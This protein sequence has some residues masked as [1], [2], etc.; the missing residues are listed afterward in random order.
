MTQ[1]T[2]SSQATGTHRQLKW[3]R[4]AMAYRVVGRLEREEGGEQSAWQVLEFLCRRG[5]QLDH[6]NTW[7]C[8]IAHLMLTFSPVREAQLLSQ[9]AKTGSRATRTDRQ[10]DTLCN[11]ELV[12]WAACCHIQYDFLY[13][14]PTP[15]FISS[16][17][18]VSVS[19]SVP[20]STSFFQIHTFV[21][22]Y[23]LP[24]WTSTFFG[25][26]KLLRSVLEIS[27]FT[28]VE[29]CMHGQA[30]SCHPLVWLDSQL[31]MSERG[32]WCATQI[33]RQ[34]KE[35]TRPWQ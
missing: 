4:F 12:I 9:V 31:A 27:A 28:A 32:I 30:I 24:S 34:R 15:T 14:P 7:S 13:E 8:D 33:E 18:S 16:L 3:H 6:M 2:R 19:V 5:R 22:A 20:K 25:E 1:E 26:G 23:T 21:R 17:V 29:I 35:H 10:F 11:T